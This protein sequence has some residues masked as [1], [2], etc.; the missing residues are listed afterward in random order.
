MGAATRSIASRRI[1]VSSFFLPRS[2]CSSRICGSGSTKLG[3]WHYLFTGT[4]GR[5][6]AALHQPT[7]REQL[8]GVQPVAAGDERDRLAGQIGL[9]DEAHLLLG[10]LVPPALD[11]G[12]HLDALGAGR[13]V[14]TYHT[15]GHR[16]TLPQA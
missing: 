8:V 5:E 9:L 3:G 2:R 11:G 6:R 4:G 14:G 13:V 10:G 15:V 7:P 16:H 12:D 1:S